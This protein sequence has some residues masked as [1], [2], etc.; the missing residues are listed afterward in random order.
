MSQITCKISVMDVEPV[1]ELVD[2]IC[3]YPREKMPDDLREQ[4]E[5]WAHKWLKDE[6]STTTDTPTHS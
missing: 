2:I 6:E 3:A 5:G 4:I 1:T